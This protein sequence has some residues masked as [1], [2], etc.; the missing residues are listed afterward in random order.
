MPVIQI[1]SKELGARGQRVRELLR[2]LSRQPHGPVWKAKTTQNT[3]R[4]G[5]HD[6]SPPS[7]DPQEWR[8]AT[9]VHGLRAEYLLARQSDGMVTQ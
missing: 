8:F 2:P 6:G 4:I 7:S 1:T 3:W 5:T 9:F